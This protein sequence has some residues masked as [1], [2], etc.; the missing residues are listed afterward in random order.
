MPNDT[1]C[2]LTDML[3]SA[4]LA[5]LLAVDNADLTRGL[6]VK[7]PPDLTPA[8]VLAIIRKSALACPVCAQGS[9]IMLDQTRQRG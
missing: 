1:K 3:V 5:A 7:P 6:T 2:V 9:T 4:L 8:M